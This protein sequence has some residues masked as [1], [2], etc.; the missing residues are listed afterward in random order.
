MCLDYDSFIAIVLT[1][2]FCWGGGGAAGVP[3]WGCRANVGLGSSGLCNFR[4]VGKQ[5]N[6]LGC[7]VSG[8]GFR[9]LKRSGTQRG[10]I[11]QSL[12]AGSDSLPEL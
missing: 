11:F 6:R 12:T 7:R 5:A 4:A 10:A 3:V 9:A 1:L 2:F 8:L